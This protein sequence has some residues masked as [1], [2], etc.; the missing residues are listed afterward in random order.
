MKKILIGLIVSMMSLSVSAQTLKFHNEKFKIVQF[1]DIHY[2]QGNPASKQAIECINEVV[3]A[4]QPDLIVLTGDIIYSK[5]GDFALQSILNV[6]ADLH[7]PFCMISGNHDVEQDTPLTKLYDMAQKAPYSVM[8]ARTGSLFDY[9]LPIYSQNG[10][11]PE[12]LLYAFDTHGGAQVKGIGNYRWFTFNQLAWYRNQSAAYKKRHGG[13]TIP[14]LAFM[15]YPLPEYNE[16]VA[17]TQ[18]VM[19]GTRMEKAFAPSLNSG[20]FAMMKEMGDV[21]GVFCGHDHDN[22]YS[23]MYYNVMLAHGR[24]S[25]GNTEYNHLRNGARVI[26]L[27]E[28]KRVFETWIHE[29]GGQ[30]LYQTTYPTSYKKDNWKLRTGTR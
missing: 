16:A 7:T 27:Y 24:Y 26:V 29:R 30:I 25:G 5:P 6:L 12:A 18:V 19:Y 4:E 14:A 2:V 17:N 28:N 1:T 22:D 21:M 10:A 13:K 3:K 23:L 9:T 11:T 20:M 8:P 15:H